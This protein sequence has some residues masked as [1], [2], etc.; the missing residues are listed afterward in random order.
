MR[1]AAPINV[2]CFDDGPVQIKVF[3]NWETKFW[4]TRLSG[5]TLI[6]KYVRDGQISKWWWWCERECGVDLR[7]QTDGGYTITLMDP[8][9][10]GGQGGVCVC[11][12]LYLYISSRVNVF[13]RQHCGC[14]FN[15]NLIWIIHRIQSLFNGECIALSSIGGGAYHQACA[16]ARKMRWC[17]RTSCRHAI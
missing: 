6:N 14:T 10:A 3:Q 5:G 1:W 7:Y 15:S 2:R 13:T 4:K 16:F 17:K 12:Y 8:R 11:I 9:C